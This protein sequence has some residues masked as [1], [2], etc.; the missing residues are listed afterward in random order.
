MLHLSEEQ[1]LYLMG[2]MLPTIPR[3]WD[4]DIYSLRFF[5]V[6]FRL[7]HQNNFFYSNYIFIYMYIK[8]TCDKH[9]I[10]N[11]KTMQPSV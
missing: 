3:D 5:S 7:R 8:V 4:L 1:T 10:K 9:F 11:H 6:K 2:T